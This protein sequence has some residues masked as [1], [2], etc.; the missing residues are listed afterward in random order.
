MSGIDRFTSKLG[1]N[2]RESMG[3]TGAAGAGG[4]LPGPA[5]VASTQYQGIARPREALTIPLG[6]I[7][8]DPDQPRKEFDEGPLAELAASLKARGQLQPVRVRWSEPAGRWVIIAGERRYRAAVMAGLPTLMCVEAKGA[9]TAEEILEEQLVENCIREDLKPIEQARAFKALIDRRGCSYRQLSES[10]GISHMA[11]SRAL[12]LLNLPE[13]VQA[14]VQSGDLPA[15]SANAI[16]KLD[17]PRD[18]REVADRVVS[19]G[20]TRAETERE[21]RQV[22]AKPG[23]AGPRGRAAIRARPKRP[24]VRAI[25]TSAAKVTIEFRKAVELAE[26]LAAVEEVAD[27]LRAE[28]ADGQAAA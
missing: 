28:L 6:R 11:V 1:G 18:Q 10:L 26:V 3:G 4:P 17:D 7:M 22:A 13:A 15:S 24:T 14:L 12:A 27:K 21:V 19:G 16:A 9:M 20:M 8:A 25:R 23:S 5:A 2:I